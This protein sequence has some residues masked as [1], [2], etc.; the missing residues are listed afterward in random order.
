[1]CS[2]GIVCCLCC[3]ATKKRQ[4]V[5]HKGT[6]QY[7]AYWLTQ[8]TTSPPRQALVQAARQGLA[9]L[10]A[11]AVVV[12]KHEHQPF[13]KG[14]IL[15]QLISHLAWLITLGRLPALPK[16]VRIRWAVKPSHGATY[17]GPVTFFSLFF[18]SSTELQPIPVNHFSC[19]IAQKTLF[20]VRKTLVGM[21]NV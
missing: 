2:T 8:L 20:G 12:L 21:R 5:M 9:V 11:S 14:T 7:G 18:Y 4:I 1:M 16:L 19:T 6:L 10:M 3:F 13:A 17:T 15:Y